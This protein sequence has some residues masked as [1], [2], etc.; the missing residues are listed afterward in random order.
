MLGYARICWDILG[1]GRIL[2]YDG[3]W[4][5]MLGYGGI[6]EG[7]GLH[8]VRSPCTCFAKVFCLSP[9]VSTFD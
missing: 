8:V 1:Y 3:I 5:H 9:V 2:G 7:G 4:W 6:C